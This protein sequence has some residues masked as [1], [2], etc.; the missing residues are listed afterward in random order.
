MEIVRPVAVRSLAQDVP[1]FLLWFSPLLSQ[2][3]RVF[4]VATLGKSL[5]LYR[6]RGAIH[7]RS[8]G[9]IIVRCKEMILWILGLQ[10]NEIKLDEAD[11]QV[12]QSHVSILCP[13]PQLQNRSNCRS[14]FA[15]LNL[16]HWF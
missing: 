15:L 16:S 8:E 13:D 3:S 14:D 4:L 12:R 7:P 10:L 11:S 2:L 6:P 5:L 1:L 9:L